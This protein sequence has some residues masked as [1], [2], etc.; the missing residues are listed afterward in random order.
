MVSVPLINYSS[1]WLTPMWNR[2]KINCLEDLL[3]PSLLRFGAGT[4]EVR[5][6]TVAKQL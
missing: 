4:N 2:D 5:D 1:Y 3:L 6:S